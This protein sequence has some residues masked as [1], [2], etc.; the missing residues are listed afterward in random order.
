MAD[1]AK[2]AQPAATGTPPVAP[3]GGEKQVQTP[4]TPPASPQ[5]EA[6][7]SPGDV[8]FELEKRGFNTANEALGY[9]KRYDDVIAESKVAMQEL[10]KRKEEIAV[11]EQR[12]FEREESIK[13]AALKLIA[14]RQE[15][16]ARLVQINEKLAIITK[17]GQ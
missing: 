12:M 7:L 11:S 8:L 14:Q 6:I 1:D 10:Q 17:L 16:E 15:Q 5:K 4:V 13:A 9:I 2:K 3:T